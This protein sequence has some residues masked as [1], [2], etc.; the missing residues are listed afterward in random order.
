MH[1][2]DRDGGIKGIVSVSLLHPR[3][4][5]PAIIQIPGNGGCFGRRFSIEGKRVGFLHTIAA[6]MRDEVI[7][8]DCSLSHTRDKSFPDTGLPLW[9]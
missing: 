3:P 4:V 8:V 1:L 5:S 7:F 2:V 9:T 6:T